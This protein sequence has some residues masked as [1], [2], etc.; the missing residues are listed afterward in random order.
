MIRSACLYPGCPRYAVHRGRCD[1]HRRTTT[2]RG[3][4]SG[5]QKLSRE[6]RVG[7]VCAICG[8]DYD[9]TVDHVV[10][11]SLGGTHARSNL[12]VMCRACH[13][14]HGARRDREATA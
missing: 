6:L 2:Q 14:R 9:L 8:S 4:G 10:P 13:G 5:W 12:Q 3:Y 11:Q 7:R 1:V